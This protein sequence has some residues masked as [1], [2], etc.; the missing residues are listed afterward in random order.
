MFV[1]RGE[2]GLSDGLL[3]G[4]RGDDLDPRLEVHGSE[5]DVGSKV[6]LNEDWSCYNQVDPERGTERGIPLTSSQVRSP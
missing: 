1:E 2:E 4:G 3:T 6:D 5:V